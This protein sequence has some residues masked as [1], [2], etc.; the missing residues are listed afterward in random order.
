MPYLRRIIDDELD[1]LMRSL[2]AIAIEGAKGVGKTATAMRRART[3]HR[4]DDPE[5]L[6]IVE[7]EPQRLVAGQTPILIDEWQRLPQSWDLVRRAVDDGAAAG[8]FL[9]TGSARPDRPPTHSGAGRIISL[10]MRPMSL[11]ERHPGVAT[12]SLAALLSGVHANQS[13]TGETTSGLEFY[14]DEIIHSGLPGASGYEDRALREY[15]DGYLARVIDRDLAE[16]TGKAVRNTPALERWL[17]SYAAAT[18][19]TA[20]FEKIRDAA[21]VGENEKPAKQTVLR[22][23]DALEQM[24]I[25][26]PIPAWLPT[27]NPIAR[28]SAPPKHQ[29]ADPAL[30]AAKLGL[31]A[32]ALLNPPSADR[33]DGPTVRDGAM[34]GRL[35]EGLV[36]LSV[37]TYAQAAEARVRHLRTIGGDREIDLICAR[38]DGKILAIEIKL[39]RTVRDADLSHL[40]WL[41]KKIGDD[42]IDSI[43]VT[44]GSAAYRRPDGI[45]VVPAVLLGP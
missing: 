38:R 8:S 22:Y 29:L 37:R 16:E 4:L 36:A 15:L 3:I 14:V 11:A 41:K 10:R 44:T 12:V 24:W 25:A 18:A 20:S 13:L 7:G 19:T 28:I 32:H 34:L 30:A 27:R 6:A 45:A 42:L 43:V 1:L 40:H 5:H 26:D 21:T 33:A 39:K 23:R 31:D 17:Y 2:P 9:L 35:F